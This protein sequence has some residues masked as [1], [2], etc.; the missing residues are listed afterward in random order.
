MR[1]I[2]AAVLRYEPE[3]DYFGTDSSGCAFADAAGASV[4]RD[5]VRTRLVNYRV[6]NATEVTEKYTQQRA[7]RLRAPRAGVQLSENASPRH[8]QLDGR[9]P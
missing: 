1:N 7:L 8:S 9:N 5:R 3:R 6:A 2:T 4:N